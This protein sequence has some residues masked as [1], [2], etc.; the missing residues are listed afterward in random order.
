MS[1]EQLYLAYCRYLKELQSGKPEI[2]IS[3]DELEPLGF[4]Q[5]SIAWN[6]QSDSAKQHWRK[7]FELGYLEV[8]QLEITRLTTPSDDLSEIARAA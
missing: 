5:F 6:R 2:G 3:N 8:S 1:D 4:D 7:R